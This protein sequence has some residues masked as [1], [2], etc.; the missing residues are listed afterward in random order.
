MVQSSDILVVLVDYNVKS[1]YWRVLMNPFF[2]FINYYIL[3]LEQE[4]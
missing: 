2:S 4:F 3:N 1:P